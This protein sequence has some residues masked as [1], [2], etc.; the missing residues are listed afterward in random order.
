MRA[1]YSLSRR[2]A[3]FDFFPWLVMQAQAGAT[4]I[5]FDDSRPTT[6]KWPVSVVRKR[7]ESI[8]LPGPALL[9]LKCEIGSTGHELAPYHQ[10]DMVKLSKQ[11][12][13]FPRLK[14][15]LPPKNKQYT[16]TLRNTQRAGGRNS[17]VS[18]WMDFAALINAHVI[19]D[20]DDCPVHLHER[21][22]LYAGAKMNFFVTNGP[23]MLCFLSDYPAMQFGLREDATDRTIGITGRLPWLLPQHHQVFESDTFENVIKH[24]NIWKRSSA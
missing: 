21:M 2:I 5:V 16:I 1:L 24:F 18:A 10:A 17:N 15:V 6:V 9:G 8:L 7:F 14:S 20:Y 12:I 4:C 19:P 3:G 11:G 23:A 22:S 13:K